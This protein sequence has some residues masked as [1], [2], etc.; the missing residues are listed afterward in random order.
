MIY[1][2]RHFGM[3]R[4][5]RGDTT[6]VCPV[7]VAAVKLH[8]SPER[9]RKR[10]GGEELLNISSPL[11]LFLCQ[12]SLFPPSL[13]FLHSFLTGPG[14]ASQILSGHR[15]W[16]TAGHREL[17]SPVLSAP[18][19]PRLSPPCPS[20]PFSPSSSRGTDIGSARYYP[21]EIN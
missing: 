2:K 18:S 21:C 8:H 14:R 13:S 1:H 11:G 16:H 20:L 4:R 17:L 19:L 3:R 15:G 9:E 5:R 12:I 7:S 10:E 6:C